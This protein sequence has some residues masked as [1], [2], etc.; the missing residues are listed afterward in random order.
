MR[1]NPRSSRGARDRGS[2][3]VMGLASLGLDIDIFCDFLYSVLL[4]N[5]IFA[6]DFLGRALSKAAGLSH[7]QVALLC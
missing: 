4:V 3:N 7:L 2:P 1:P 5:A 6:L